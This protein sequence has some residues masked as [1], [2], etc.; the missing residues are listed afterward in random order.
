MKIISGGQTG[1]DR[2][3]LKIAKQFG[4]ETGGWMPREFEAEDGNHPEF[5]DQYGVEACGSDMH[6][7]RTALNAREAE[8]TLWF[9]AGA[10]GGRKTTFLSAKTCID[11]PLPEAAPAPAE[12]ADKIRDAKI[13]NIAGHRESVQP[14]IEKLTTDYL[15]QLFEALGYK[16]RQ[17]SGVAAS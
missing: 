7:V 10:S 8:I 15:V 17:S 9:G 11:I 4:L 13:V 14:G 2:A 5:A 1:A 3:A 16:R 12:V 6:A